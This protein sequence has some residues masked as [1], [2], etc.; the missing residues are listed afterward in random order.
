MLLSNDYVPSRTRIVMRAYS[1][2]VDKAF[3]AAGPGLWNSLPSHLKEA[4]LSYNRFR[5]LLKTF[6]LDIGAMAQCELH[7]VSKNKQNYFR[8]NYVKLPTKSDNFWRKDGK[9]SKIL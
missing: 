6:R 1:I 3:A 2:S 7:R 4:D 5:W 9:L 8:Y